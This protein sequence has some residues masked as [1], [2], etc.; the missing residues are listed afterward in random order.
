MQVKV[1]G[2]GGVYWGEVMGGGQNTAYLGMMGPRLPNFFMVN[3]PNT[4]LGHGR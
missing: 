1:W 4:A 3:G 2:R